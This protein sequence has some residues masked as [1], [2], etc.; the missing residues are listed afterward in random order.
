MRRIA[1]AMWLS[2]CACGS[3][4]PLIPA[5]S[6]QVI[7]INNYLLSPQRLV[8]APGSVVLVRNQDPFAH[9]V[10]SSAQPGTYVFGV[11]GGVSFDT[12]EFVGE[13]SV[14]IP[15]TAQVG[16]VIPYFCRLHG[17]ALG[18]QGQIEIVPGP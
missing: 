9:T 2:A 14:D 18:E 15:S 1:C 17:A 6:S 3:T 5:D 8:V 16:A 4:S 7:T 11:A 12:G 13:R 10:T